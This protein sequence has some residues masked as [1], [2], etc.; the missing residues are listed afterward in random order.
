MFEKSKVIIS[1]RLELGNYISGFDVYNSLLLNRLL[2]PTLTKERYKIVNYEY[3]PDLVAK[4]IYGSEDYMAILL[5]TT[6]KKVEEFKKGEYL[7][8][9]PKLVV[10]SIIDSI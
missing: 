9:L 4:D 7:D 10:D 6:G 2:D 1:N 8:V 3:R 5:I